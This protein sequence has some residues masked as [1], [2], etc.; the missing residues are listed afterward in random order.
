MAL[1]LGFGSIEVD[2]WLVDQHGSKSLLAGHIPV[3]LNRHRTLQ[4]LYLDP[5]FTILERRNKGRLPN[6]TWVGLLEDDPSADVQL[7]IDFVCWI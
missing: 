5:I 2:T 3:D 1:G 7:V 6:E 4:S